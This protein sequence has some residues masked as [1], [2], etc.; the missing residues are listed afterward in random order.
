MDL[1]VQDGDAGHLRD[2]FPLTKTASDGLALLEG[3]VWGPPL[4][5]STEPT[6]LPG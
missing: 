2:A 5:E 4:P 1:T 3:L 6:G